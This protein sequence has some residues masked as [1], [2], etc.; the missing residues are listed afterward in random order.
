MTLHHSAA[1]AGVGSYERE[2][3]TLYVNYGGAGPTPVLQLRKLLEE[4][5]GEWGPVENIHI[6]PDKTIA[7]VR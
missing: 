2:C 7:F 1:R 4:N 5:F 6:V 3:R